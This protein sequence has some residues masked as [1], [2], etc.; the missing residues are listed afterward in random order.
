MTEIDGL[1]IHFIHVRSR[2]PNALPLIITHGWPGSVLE[3]LKVIDPLTNPTAHRRPRRR[4][5]R[6][7]H[8]LDA[9]LRLLRPADEHGMGPRAHG[10][11]LGRAHEAPGLH[12]LCGPG[13]RLGFG[14][15][16][17]D[18]APGAGGAAGHPRQHAC[19]RAAELAKALNNGDPAPAGLSADEKAAFDHS[20]T[21]FTK[22]AGY[23]AI[24]VTRPQTVG[25][26]LSDSPV[27]LA[28]WFYDKF[29]AVDVQR[30]RSRALTDQGRDARR[31]HAVLADQQRGLLARAVLGEQQQ[32]LQLRRRR[33]PRR[34]RSPWP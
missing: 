26:G 12:A 33:R 34:S 23:G 30:R 8:S 4:R 19:H 5:L 7:R 11:R 24:M 25:Y 13:R 1:D 14:R 10:P 9:R 18:G 28:A 15:R 22:N 27:G 20:S 16:G 3:L 6:R 2:H 17:R 32:Q 29:V 21:F 31:H